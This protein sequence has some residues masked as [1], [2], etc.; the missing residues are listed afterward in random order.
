MYYYL[1]MFNKISRKIIRPVSYLATLLTASL[2][3]WAQA[4]SPPVGPKWS[5]GDITGLIYNILFPIAIIY[6]VFEIIVAGYRIMTSE[7]EPRKLDDAKAHLTDSL[8]GVLFVV[9]AVV[10]LRIIIKSFLA[11]DL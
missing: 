8:V 9:L 7:G 2:P 1:N 6:G 10:I 4:T 5:L 3:V 11:Q